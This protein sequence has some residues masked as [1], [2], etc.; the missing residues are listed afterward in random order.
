MKNIRNPF[1]GPQSFQT[2]D[3]ER[4][5]G[6]ESEIYELVS[7][8]F[9][10]P[11]ILLY[12]QSGTGKTSLLNAGVI[13]EIRKEKFE[14][15]P[16]IRVSLLNRKPKL[17][18]E[19]KNIY[20]YNSLHCLNPEIENSEILNLTEISDFLGYSDRPRL[21]V[22]DQFEEIFNTFPERWEDR[23]E[24]FKQ[25]G[26]ALDLDPMLRVIFSI[27]EDYLAYFDP[28]EKHL[29]EDLK[30][31]FRLERLKAENAYSSIVKPIQLTNLKFQTGV[32]EELI[33]DLLKVNVESFGETI[34]IKGEY[35]E[36]VQLQL[37]CFNLC[38]NL[39]EDTTEITSEYIKKLNDIDQILIEFY[40]DAVRK[41]TTEAC[42]NERELRE[43]IEKN[44]ITKIGTRGSIYRGKNETGFLP[45]SI[46][47]FLEKQHI[48]K[49]E[50]RAG[51]RWYELT[52]DRFISPIQKSN[53]EFLISSIENGSL[54]IV[55]K[56]C[57]KAKIELNHN[58]L[59]KALEYY[60][61]A[62]QVLEQLENKEKLYETYYSIGNI[63]CDLENFLDA[64]FSFTKVIEEFP[65][66]PYAHYRLGTVY[67]YTGRLTQAIFEFS[68][69]LNIAKR[70]DDT[71][72]IISIYHNRGQ[73]YTELGRYNEALND[74]QKAINLNEEYGDSIGFARNGLAYALGCIGQY[75]ASMSEFKK[76]INEHPENAWVYY[77][78]AIILERMG[79]I[80]NAIL[81]FQI[82]LDKNDPS[83][84]NLRKEK[85]IEKIKKLRNNNL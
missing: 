9:A 77:N 19:I 29:H 18:S 39:D 40:N 47:D 20:V 51:A 1:V 33:E 16:T 63:Q 67:W 38:Q 70:T 82:S 61:D 5:F 15:L 8:I 52:H 73:I 25:I 10:H 80:E 14:V 17:F 81:N 45:N 7:L 56:L 24:F 48:L 85:A 53:K 23:E 6:R 78:K 11:I 42:F 62:I 43:K 41:V 60:N 34:R 74:L 22:F 64:E 58:N 71:S 79:D 76:A 46:V 57:R 36:P 3:K 35:I 59:E 84:N 68:E 44:F 55:G 72:L 26:K 75:D 4:F 28:V 2:E 32:V 31:R 27:R 30:T 21:L 54:D 65:S 69:A 66:F 83:L 12:G 13:P 50:R 37:V 49:A